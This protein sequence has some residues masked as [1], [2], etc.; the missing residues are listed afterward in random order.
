MCPG[1]RLGEAPFLGGLDPPLCQVGG[2]RRDPWDAPAGPVGGAFPRTSVCWPAWVCGLRSLGGRS[3]QRHFAGGVAGSKGWDLRPHQSKAGTQAMPTLQGPPRWEAPWPGALG[4][5][6]CPGQPH[7][8]GP[9]VAHK[10]KQNKWKMLQFYQ[11]VCIVE[12]LEKYNRVLRSCIS[13][14]CHNTIPQTGRLK[15]R[16]FIFSQIWMLGV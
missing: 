12:N 8:P 13:S 9:A 1:V 3:C 2:S 14:G 7:P 10:P 11:L 5:G 6:H 15:Q 4:L 16:K